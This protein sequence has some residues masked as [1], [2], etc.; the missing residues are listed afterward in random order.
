MTDDLAIWSVAMSAL[1]VALGSFAVTAARRAAVGEG[2][3]SGRSRCDHCRAQLTFGRTL[4]LWSFVAQRGRCHQCHERISASHPSGE[5]AGLLC[6]ASA[7]LV[8]PIAQWPVA[9]A[10]GAVLIFIAAYDVETLQIPN[11]ANILVVVLGAT[12]ALQRQDLGA[13]L[14]G[15]AALAAVLALTAAGF[16]RWRGKAG[17]GGGDIKLVMGLAVWTGPM[18]GGL[19]LAAACLA[20]LA[21]SAS[22]RHEGK[23]PFGPFLS[24]G[25][26]TVGLAGAAT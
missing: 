26:W 9:L 7:S 1:G 24:V 8:L 19:G 22:T 23:L 3:L 17:L 5:L 13:S 6:G 14:V 21:W 18:L 15:A 16:R 12:S 25:F 4:P 2:A 20:G 11:W 10:L